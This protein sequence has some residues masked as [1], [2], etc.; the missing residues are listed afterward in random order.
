MTY[1]ERL[2]IFVYWADYYGLQII[3]PKYEIDDKSTD[4]AK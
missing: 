2:N 3:K 4:W 1:Q